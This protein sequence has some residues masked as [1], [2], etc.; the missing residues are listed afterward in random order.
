MGRGRGKVLA[1]QHPGG[2]RQGV[3]LSSFLPSYG[4]ASVQGSPTC[5]SRR[6]ELNAALQPTTIGRPPS[7]APFLCDWFI[8]GHESSARHSRTRHPPSPLHGCR[9]GSQQ[10]RLCTAGQNHVFQSPFLTFS[11]FLSPEKGP[12]DPRCL[13]PQFSERMTRKCR[14]HLAGTPSLFAHGLLLSSGPLMSHGL[15]LT[16]RFLLLT[17][18]VSFC[19]SVQ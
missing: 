4:R 8:W 15:R 1:V 2:S 13:G 3:V 9:S 16:C 6:A 19:S 11:V 12:E 7:T 5:K 14:P 10:R 18:S 17:A